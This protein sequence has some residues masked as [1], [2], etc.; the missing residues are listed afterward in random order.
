GEESGCKPLL[1]AQPTALRLCRWAGPEGYSCFFRSST[2]P[3]PRLS[4]RSTIKNCASTPHHTPNDAYK[5]TDQTPQNPPS[6]GF[7]STPPNSP[8]KS[9]DYTTHK[10]PAQTADTSAAYSHPTPLA[11]DQQ[12]YSKTHT[13]PDQYGAS[14]KTAAPGPAPAQTLPPPGAQ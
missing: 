8:A 2:L 12:K 1:C 13:H 6:D 7:D 11:A 9:A 14:E 4:L 3:H 5:E 10:S